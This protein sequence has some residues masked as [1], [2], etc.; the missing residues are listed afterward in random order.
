MM[1]EKERAAVFNEVCR[2]I[3]SGV[4]EA[5]F[6]WIGEFMGGVLKPVA[7]YA[8]IKNNNKAFKALVEE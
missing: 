2:M 7:H 5:S 6:V 1:R 4:K 3:T 8:G